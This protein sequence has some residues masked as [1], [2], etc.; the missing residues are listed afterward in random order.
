MWHV[1]SLLLC[2]VVCK[3]CSYHGRFS[4]GCKHSTTDLSRLH[5][6]TTIASY[7]WQSWLSYLH[8]YMVGL[9]RKLADHEQT[10]R[11]TNKGATPTGVPTIKVGTT[12]L[13]QVVHMQMQDP[14]PMILQTS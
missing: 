6:I 10:E 1:I 8:S 9:D 14:W 12:L 7:V 5:T 13:A 4:Y 2:M 11:E 3:V